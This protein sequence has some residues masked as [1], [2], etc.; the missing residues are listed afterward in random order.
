MH[1]YNE[2]LK[3]IQTQKTKPQTEIVNLEKAIGRYLVEEIESTIFLP[4]YNKSAMDGIAVASQDSSDFFSIIE[5][6]GAGDVPGASL[7]RGDC[8]KIMTGA[9]MPKGADKVIRSENIKTEGDKVFVTNPEK[10]SNVIKKGENLK[11]GKLV[12]TPRLIRPS[13]IAVLASLGINPV[14]VLKKPKVGIIITGSELIEPGEPV[15]DY[16]IYNC[17]GPQLVA[18]ATEMGCDTVYYGIIRDNMENIKNT[19][20]RAL[21]ECDIVLLSGGVSMGDFDFVPA[22]LKENDVEIHFHNVGIKPGKPSLF[23]RK[24]ET[25]VFGLPGNPVAVFVIFEIFVKPLIAKVYGIP[26]SSKNEDG[27]LE[28]SIDRKDAGR[29]SFRPVRIENGRIIPLEY[30]GSSHINA[31]SDA[32]GLIQLEK[33][34]KHIEQGSKVTVRIF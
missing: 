15:Q 29:E 19:I 6:I 21:F 10:R 5:I 8:A 20:S 3:I 31:L 34:L 2:A 30:H 28:N 17:N 23:G 22:A 24:G 26:Y 33:G 9:M 32:N 4:P 25:F 1:S 14:K 27:I 18:Q 12:L 7:K 16:S 13:D 11:P